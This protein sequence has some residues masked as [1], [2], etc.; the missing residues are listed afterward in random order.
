MGKISSVQSRISPPTTLSVVV[1][2]FNEESV[3][4]EFHARLTR[5][6]DTL[7]DTSE[8][9]YVNDGSTDNSQS[10]VESFSSHTSSIKCIALSR[11][12][13]KE[14]ALSAGLAH[15]SGLAVIAID[16]DLQDPPELIPA[17][18]TKWREGFDVVNMQRS[19]RLGESWLKK[20][21]AAVFYSLLNLMS[22]TDIPENVGDF[23]LIAREVVDH[24]NALPERNRYMKGI[25]SWPGFKQA[26]LP[27]TRDPRFCGESKWNYFKLVG[28]AI[29]GITSFSIRP[30]RAATVLGLIIAS[31]AFLYGLFVVSK[32]LL[33][34]EPVSGYPSLMVVQLA[35]G[36][37]QLITIG[38]LGEYI[39]RIFIETKQRPLYLIQSYSEKGAVHKQTLSEK[40][41]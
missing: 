24:I 16:A 1:P 34:G 22:Q 14:S 31:S 15:S 3:L 36:G 18:L 20:K 30:L 35:L 40:R 12:F 4:C 23:R 39:G 38:L 7:S 19:E 32:T 2:Y 29:D 13:G 5:V 21:S 25:F 6:L 26:T 10:L 11:N 27:F 9:V 17:M 37:I 28:L 41:A 33:F 8:I